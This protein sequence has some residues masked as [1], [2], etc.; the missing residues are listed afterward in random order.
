LQQDNQHTATNCNILQQTAT[1]RN[2]LQHTATYCNILQPTATHCSTL[3]HTDNTQEV[4]RR[5]RHTHCNR[6]INALQ[7][8]AT[9]CNTQTK[10]KRYAEEPDN[11]EL[12]Y[13][14]ELWQVYIH[15]N[16]LQ[17][18]TLQHTATHRNKLGQAKVLWQVE[19]LFLLQC[20]AECCRVL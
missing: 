20:F 13:A 3:Q 17:H 7:H 8:T 19:I 12:G 6:T 10:P 4:R 15:C 14:N 2:I 5:A 1:Y 16:A 9:H 11:I 18:N